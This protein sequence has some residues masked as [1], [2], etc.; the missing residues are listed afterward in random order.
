M[1]TTAPSSPS[2]SSLGGEGV[3][4]DGS[5]RTKHP[6]RN[7]RP[8]E[9]AATAADPAA[10][11]RAVSNLV[12]PSDPAWSSPLENDIRHSVVTDLGFL[13]DMYHQETGTT[14]PQG[15]SASSSGSGAVAAGAQHVDSMGGSSSGG[16]GSGGAVAAQLSAL[17]RPSQADHRHPTAKT[18]DMPR[19]VLSDD[20]QSSAGNGP[21]GGSGDGPGG[22]SGDAVGAPMIPHG[23]LGQGLEMLQ[24][25][26]A[27]GSGS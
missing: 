14:Q 24:K 12:G 19:N 2:S 20:V 9:G 23:S 5:G 10:A 15:G 4:R 8:T 16:G 17:V 27:S 25:A 6:S 13:M 1:G 11:G 26:F 3:G 21:G 18:G 7:V 22:G